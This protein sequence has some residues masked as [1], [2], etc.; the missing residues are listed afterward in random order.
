[1][2][3]IGGAE[4]RQ[5]SPYGAP[6]RIAWRPPSLTDQILGEGDR[7][8]WEGGMLRI[9]LNTFQKLQRPLFSVLAFRHLS[10]DF[11]HVVALTQTRPS[12][13]SE[14]YHNVGPMRLACHCQ[15]SSSDIARVRAKS[16]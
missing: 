4:T 5:Q 16:S 2:P 9:L 11:L 14:K 6:V 10:G 7:P 15:I 8:M 1:M 3:Y 12:E 13:S